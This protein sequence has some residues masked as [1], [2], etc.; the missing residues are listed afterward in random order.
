[1]KEEYIYQLKGLRKNYQTLEFA[2][3]FEKW[4]D[5][6]IALEF[7]SKNMKHSS[8]KI[9]A[10]HYIENFESLNIEKYK[11]LTPAEIIANSQTQM[12]LMDY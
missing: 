9:T 11:H 1:M 8:G 12:R 10:Y 3:Q 7:T 2:K 5:A 4:Q 6:S